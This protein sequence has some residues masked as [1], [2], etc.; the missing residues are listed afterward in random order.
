MKFKYLILPL[1]YLLFN[2]FNFAQDKFLAK[3]GNIEISPLEFKQRFEL[4]PKEIGDFES[5]SS[6][7]NFLYSLISEKLWAIEAESLSM[8]KVPYVINSVNNIGR[9]LVKD[10][11]YKLEIES[12]VK[13]TE[14]EI[15]RDVKKVY[16]K[17]IM[18]FLFSKERSEIDMLYEKLIFGVLIDSLLIGRAEENEQIDGIP[19]VYGQMEAKLEDKLFTLSINQFTEPIFM[20]EGWVIYYLKGIESV[21]M[22][23]DNRERAIQKRV[24]DV[25]FARKAEGYYNEFFNANVKGKRVTSDKYLFRKLVDEIFTLMLEKDKKLFNKHENKYQL[26][27][28]S[29]KT[30]RNTFSNNELLSDFIKFNSSP[31]SLGGYLTHLELNGFNLEKV[32]KEAIN[33]ALNKN[34]KAFIFEEI[35]VR[36]GYQRGLQNSK[37][38]REELRIWRQ[39]F[40]ASYYRHSYLDS[41]NTNDN[42]AKELYQK[43]VSENDN[44]NVESFEEVKE[45]IKSGQYFNKLQ[46]LYIN[47]TVSFAKK[48][49]VSIDSKKLNSIQVTNIEMMVYRYLG[50]GGEI[51]ALPYLQPF[52]KWKYWLPKSL[53]LQLP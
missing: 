26:D 47:K 6:K 33:S 16:E 38:I 3:V 44:A 18:K 28:Y 8:E 41:I 30:I 21:P 52:Y 12:K 40:L 42:E 20:R 27:A 39:S 32:S 23:E 17:R 13:I 25:I 10:K 48:Y 24:E 11:L 51:T 2:P 50:F 9:K 4:S 15:A 19:V 22:P 45:K 49:G 46:D 31:V 14:E 5:D 34:V 1:I 37:E 36:E 29:V 53:K 7:V 43:I 35:L